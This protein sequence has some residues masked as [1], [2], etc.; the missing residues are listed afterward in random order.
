MNYFESICCYK[1]D[2]GNHLSVFFYNKPTKLDKVEKVKN[3]IFVRC[4]DVRE[5]IKIMDYI[6]E[7]NF[8]KIY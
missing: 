5:L 8:K 1:M 6:K 4:T 7:N 2:D 3:G